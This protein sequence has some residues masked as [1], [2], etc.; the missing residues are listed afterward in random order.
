SE[1]ARYK[2]AANRELTD[3]DKEI[4]INNLIQLTLL[5]QAAYTE[6]FEIDD[7]ALQTRLEEL[8]SENQPLEDWL[9]NYGYTE[10]SFRDS[11]RRSLAAAWMRDKIIA[12]VPEQAEQVHAQQMLFYTI[13][14]ANN[15]LSQLAEGVNFA[16]LAATYDPQTNGDLGWFPRGYLTVPELDEV[17][18][19]LEPREYSDIIETEIGFHIIWLI[20]KEQNRPIPQDILRQRQQQ[21]VHDW[22]ERRQKL[23]TIE[24][25]LP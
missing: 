23:S 22:L 15:A 24:I 17:I 12:N 14:Q 11:L 19:S 21:A 13:G 9:A 2:A 18:F 25:T 1:L 6:G 20:E 10:E 5:A 16:Q 3:E 8:D 4:V 7:A